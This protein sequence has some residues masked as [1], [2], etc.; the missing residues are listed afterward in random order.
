MR[1]RSS[2]HSPI[3]LFTFLDTLVCTMGSLILMLLAMTPKIRE[4]AE[5]RELARLAALAPSAQQ[6]PEPPPA[7]PVA[8]S[9]AI[10]DEQECSAARQRRRD[11]WLA[12]LADA[13]GGLEKEQARYLR[14]R[15][16]LKDAGS[17]L[18]N[19]HDQIRRARAKAEAA[20]DASQ[21][22]T[23]QETKLQEYQAK[24]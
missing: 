18:K 10:A 15:E 13:R 19:V 6:E 20:A 7:E 17:Q 5:A 4:R 23:E 21:S 22:L 3:S 1:R 11:A 12:S 8:P 2:S 9:P 16:I 14:Q 24:I